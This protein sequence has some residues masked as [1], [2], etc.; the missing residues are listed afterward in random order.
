MRNGN[1]DIVLNPD[2][3]EKGIPPPPSDYQ[4]NKLIEQIKNYVD[5]NDIELVKKAFW[6]AY[7]K[8]H[9]QT[10][11]SG[12]TYFTH[13]Y[14]V[15]LILSH[16][17]ADG[18][19]IS[20]G[21][22]HDILEDTDYP[23]DKIKEIFGEKV[24]HLVN[25]VT[26]L[27]KF[28]FSSKE[29]RQAE[30]FRKMFLAMAKDIRVIIVKLADR[31]HNMRTLVHLSEEKQRKIAKETLEI[32]APLAHRLGIGKI[33]WEL[34]DLCFRYLH[35]EYYWKITKS[36]AERRE[37]REA[38]VNAIIERLRMELNSY[39]ITAEIT[40]RPKHFYSI[41]QK[42]Q[43]QQ[44]D[45]GDLYD[46]L[47]VRVVINTEQ[48]C[49][50]SLG[51]IHSLWPPIAGRFK[52][53]VA[54][55]KPN[56]YQSLHTTVMA[57][58]G[59]PLEVQIRTQQMHRVAEFGIAAH[60][61]YK[62]SGSKKMRESASDL[63]LAWLRQLLEWQ[64][65]IK[66]EHEYMDTVKVDLFA[67]EVFV[68]SPKGDVYA[69]T[70]G[71]TPLDFAYAIHTEV[72]HRCIGAKI[73]GRIVPLETVLQNGDQVEIM[74]SK[75]S[76][77]RL[78]WINF[79]ATAGARSKIRQW[80]KK[81]K[82]EDNIKRGKE[83]LEAELGKSGLEQLMKSEKL[84]EVAKA[85]R[86][87]S[88]D[89]LFAGIGYGEVTVMQLLNRLRPEQE[90]HLLKKLTEEQEPVEKTSTPTG[91][92]VGGEKGLLITIAKCC[93]PLPGQPIIG[94]V[95]RTKGVTIH[96]AECRNLKQVKLERLI[97]VNWGSIGKAMYPAAIAIETIDRQGL[98][99]DI[100]AKV[101]DT[102]KTNILG[103]SININK[104]KT[105]TINLKVDIIDLPHLQRIMESIRKMGDVIAVNRVHRAAK[106]SQACAIDKGKGA[107]KSKKSKGEKILIVL[108][109]SQNTNSLIKEEKN[110]Q[111]KKTKKNK[112]KKKKK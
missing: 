17:N 31:L 62:V 14:E 11:A 8:H 7:E 85:L 51:I 79:V 40:G 61:K 67:D 45:F 24:F 3:D 103:L 16:L 10:R 55:P 94:V 19:M 46:I 25:S 36:I 35:P 111:S 70:Q 82:R 81:E 77:P 23:P 22:L 87:I 99:K 33:K 50:S 72:G 60:W 90:S 107:K 32:F 27:S 88:I 59:R 66:D 44:K 100:I 92:V 74:T 98:L 71:A 26:K 96:S 86:K 69:L 84:E 29:E 73:N 38:Y 30:N 9:Q 41:Y 112:G 54:M 53:F 58:G 108:D 95:T 93:S 76:Q 80:F 4:L 21:L 39:E 65:Y 102:N 37:E 105:A 63:Q 83:I 52:D 56:L 106:S 5:V 13:P 1:A 15:A 34:E 91:I 78:D 6:V 75:V 68:F 43:E 47:G 57:I 18:E 48:E 20:A 12:D 64:Q 109:K 101:S 110:K 104:N 89:D 2:F 49:Y 97:P 42:M 28:S